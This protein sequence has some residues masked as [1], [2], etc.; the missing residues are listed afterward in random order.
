MGIEKLRTAVIGLLAAVWSTAAFGATITVDTATDEFD[1][2][3]SCSLRE[4][5]VAAN[6]DAGSYNGT[7]YACNAGSGNDVIEVPAD[8]GSG[9]YALTIT[10]GTDNNDG[11]VND[12]DLFST[13][14]D[15]VEIKGVTTAGGALA[16]PGEVVIHPGSAFD[17]RAFTASTAATLKNLTVQGFASSSAGGAIYQSDPLTL[18]QVIFKRNQASGSGGAVYQ[19]AGAL[20]VEGSAFIGNTGSYGGAIYQQRD[21]Q[22]LRNTTLVRNH[23]V[24]GGG[25][26][27][28]APVDSPAGHVTLD[29]VTVVNNSSAG[30]GGGLN[31]TS[32]VSAPDLEVRNTI[33][34]G[35]RAAG[36]GPD[37]RIDAAATVG[38]STGFNLIGNNSS[39]GALDVG[40]SIANVPADLAAAGNYDGVTPMRPPL[41]ES[42]AIDA[43]SC[44]DT[45]SSSVTT[46]QRGV[47]SS[48]NVDG[49]G[50]STSDCDI[51]AVERQKVAFTVDDTGDTGDSNPGD[52]ACD[53]G[54]G[55]CTLRAAI[56]QAN[57]S[58][59][60]DEIVL[61]AGT[62]AISQSTAGENSNADG[63]YDV[64]ESLILHG[65]G[66]GDT[67]LDGGG[68]DRVVDVPNIGG[69]PRTLHLSGLTVR[70]GDTGAPSGAGT[71]EPGGGIRV[72]GG[73]NESNLLGAEAVRVTG[74]H[75]RGTSSDGGGISVTFG[76]ARIVRSTIDANEADRSGSGI[77]SSGG[78]ET[79]ILYTTVT[80]NTAGNRG[81]VTSYGGAEVSVVQSTVVANQAIAGAQLGGNSGM[82]V[83]GSIVASSAAD[84]CDFFSG[85]G[86]TSL[87]YNLEDTTDCGFAATGDVQNSPAGLATL[88][89]AGG[90]VPLREPD[91]AS[92]AV[93]AG[94]CVDADG[95]IPARAPFGGTRPQ[96]AD[97]SGSGNGDG[98]YDCDIGAAERQEVR[99]ANGSNAPSARTVSAGATGV[100]MAQFR[101]TNESGE[102]LDGRTLTLRAAGSGDESAD[103]AAVRL[104]V[105]ENGDGQLDAGDTQVQTAKTFGADDGT[106]TFDL[107]G[108]PSPHLTSGGSAQLLVVYD[109]ASS[110]AAAGFG[111]Q[112]R[113]AAAGAVPTG[114][115]ALAGLLGMGLTRRGRW[116]A[117]PALALALTACGSGG[118]G[119]GGGSSTQTETFAVAVEDLQVTGSTGGDMAIRVPPTKGATVTVED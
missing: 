54:G 99:V 64:R 82:E 61:P 55:N 102:S 83:R 88:T 75:A 72:A 62:F 7:S 56:D 115:L 31:T 57:N 47:A 100:V 17:G 66:A 20:T 22:T 86:V 73:S 44:T 109:F 12:L 114:M 67:V 101:L 91:A 60:I 103:V 68:L 36:S 84:D 8:V 58:A 3:T 77:G 1:T 4:A 81:A 38:A 24:N 89:D 104:Y 80:G 39:C 87:G 52:G 105:D 23:A 95:R 42:P 2:N 15:T 107:S 19:N 98:T 85:P 32:S 10:A 21:A 26:I 51:G 6:Q 41:T 46:D 112:P 34:A 11:T 49:D 18:D 93:D 92:A 50:D 43:G 97:A 110:L 59:D 116:L 79:R 108:L 48:R 117:V 27:E 90:P 76:G 71:S 65:A 14:S 40:S 63:D 53:D 35:N 69:S 30:A 96:D 37:C 45:S 111:G 74:N 78:A 28:L 16:D 33:L 113:V 25:A 5:V 70:N 94:Q 118:G 119:G 9:S 13:S 29:N 106:V